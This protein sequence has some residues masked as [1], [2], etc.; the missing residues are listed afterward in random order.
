DIVPHRGPGDDILLSEDR[1][2]NTNGAKLLGLTSEPGAMIPKMV[3]A[4]KSG[5]LRALVVLCENPLELGLT[6]DELRNLPAF[7]TMSISQ[8]EST[9]LSTAVLPSS[10]FAEKR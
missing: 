9:D 8:N 6:A 1:N 10:A 5:S 7:I 3:E 4:I 2:P